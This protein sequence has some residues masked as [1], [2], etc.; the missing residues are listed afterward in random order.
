MSSS[1]DGGRVQEGTTAE[2]SAVALQ[3]DDEGEVTSN[4][5]DTTD[6]FGI[7]GLIPLRD[8]RSRNSRQSCE[9][10]DERLGGHFD[11]SVMDCWLE[12][13]GAID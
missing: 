5:R 9:S 3:T 1:Q 8:R 10:D 4:G 2:V 13:G 12:A 11:W 6:N 7:V